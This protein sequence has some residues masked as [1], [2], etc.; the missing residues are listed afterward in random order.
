[1]TPPRAEIDPKRIRL[2]LALVTAV[3]LVSLVLAAIID[4]RLGRAVMAAIALSSLLRAVL[5]VR[6]VR[7]DGVDGPP[8]A[9]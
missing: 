6:S 1:V 2:G 9:S 4:D 7:R 5:L 3:F 8:S